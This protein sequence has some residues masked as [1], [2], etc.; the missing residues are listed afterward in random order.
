MTDTGLTLHEAAEMLGVHYMTAYRY[1]RLGLLPARKV[2]GSWHVT[3]A[4]VAAFQAREAGRGRAQP[5]ADTD[6]AH[7]SGRPR[8][9]WGER[10]EARL[11]A[12]DTRGAW[13]VVEAALTAGSTLEDIYLDVLTPALTAI[14]ERWAEG[15]LDISIEHRASG[16]AMRLIGRLGP[17]F[18]RRG[19]TRGL[20]VVGAP[21]G[22][23]HVLPLAM[24]A[25]LIRQRG[26]EVSDLGGDLPPRSFV[27]AVSSAGDDL[28]AVAISVSID[29][30]LAALA[31]T[32]EAIKHVVPSVLVVVGGHAIAG[33]EHAVAL[34]A[35]HYAATLG[36]IPGILE[37]VSAV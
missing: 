13:G 34:G 10:L 36:D 8:A 18:A 26:W 11:V 20:V 19:R 30:H 14:G 24:A 15:E 1:V 35:D 9:P 21:E 7:R 33:E 3:A 17:R 4:D 5:V 16:I 29:E 12:G 25:D 28:V 23:R 6:G 37:G 2:A 27:H 32:I 22:E 31:S